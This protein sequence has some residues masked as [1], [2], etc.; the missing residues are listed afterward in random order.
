MKKEIH[1]DVI[2]ELEKEGEKAKTIKEMD[3]IATKGHKRVLKSIGFYSPNTEYFTACDKNGK[4]WEGAEIK[5]KVVWDVN[6]EDGTF[7][8]ESQEIAEI[9]S[10]LVQIDFRLKRIEKE[11]E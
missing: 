8:T 3:K 11:L 2:D 5:E 10:F 7:T 1:S 6:L 9:I 4:S